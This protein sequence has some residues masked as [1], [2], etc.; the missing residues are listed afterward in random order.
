MTR[1]PD[2]SPDEMAD[3]VAALHRIYGMPGHLIRRA[4]QISV[5]AFMECT[6]SYGLTP[7]QYATLTV[8]DSY[9][10]ID[11][12]SLAS[13][14]AFD[15]STIGDVIQRLE[16]RGLLRREN[17]ED[18][19]TKLVFLTDEGGEV[20][21]AM[22]ELVLESQVRILQPLSDGEQVILLFLLSKLVNLSSEVGP[23]PLPGSASHNVHQAMRS[24]LRSTF[25]RSPAPP[26]SPRTD[27]SPSL[28]RRR[29]RAKRPG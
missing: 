28:K 25:T 17:G 19:R 16:Q 6:K 21:E 23:S 20:L 8:A 10:G 18:R 13:M 7:V 4:H 24:F 11:Q 26:L 5:A 12:R 1:D 2:L 14:V 15:R 27:E 22:D 3:S 9:P 29:P